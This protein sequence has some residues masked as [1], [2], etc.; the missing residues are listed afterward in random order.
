MS[1]KKELQAFKQAYGTSAAIKKIIKSRITTAD[2]GILY[3]LSA[4]AR[5]LFDGVLV[6]T[7]LIQRSSQAETQ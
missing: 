3:Y 4:E 2:S 6:E 5:R 7:M 1:F